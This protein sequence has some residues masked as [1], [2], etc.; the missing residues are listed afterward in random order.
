MVG[1][2]V[3]CMKSCKGMLWTEFPA[4]LRRRARPRGPRCRRQ[5]PQFGPQFGYLPDHRLSLDAPREL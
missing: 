1:G 3:P 2:A 4:S 5:R